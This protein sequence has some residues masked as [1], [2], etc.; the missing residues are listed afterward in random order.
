MFELIK[1]KIKRNRVL[2]FLACELVHCLKYIF[3]LLRILLYSPIVLFNNLLAN[4]VYLFKATYSTNSYYYINWKVVT[5]ID[6]YQFIDSPSPK[7]LILSG[8]KFLI[9]FNYELEQ[10]THTD[11]LFIKSMIRPDY[12]TFF[13]GVYQQCIGDKAITDIKLTDNKKLLYIKLIKLIVFLPLFFKVYEKGFKVSLFRYLKALTYLNVMKTFKNYQY[14][15]L[16]VF[17]DMQGVENLLVQYANKHNKRT[18]T[19]Q[20]GLYVDYSV[21]PNINIVNYESVVSQYFLAWGDETSQLI[22]KYHP[23]VKIV[24]CGKP[25][26]FTNKADPGD[27]FTIVFD[28]KL[29]YE[30]NKELLV[31]GKE[32][33]TVYGWRMNVRIHPW[34]KI[35]NYDFDN[36][37]TDFNKDLAHSQFVIGHTTSMIFECMR[38]GIPSFKYKTKYPSNKVNDSLTF[39]NAEQLISRIEGMNNYNFSEVGMYYLKYVGDESLEKYREF[40]STIKL[41]N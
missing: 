3:R 10:H 26:Y 7:R 40:F 35:E 27:Y 33:S 18:I 8:F 22:Q 5:K 41:H 20:H 4:I 37:L 39:A 25:V 24:V 30:Q 16:V 31:I 9:K 28:Q 36:E 15:T 1:D 29:F 23:D 14:S 21:F 6:Y 11:L 38:N 2:Y 32:I 12:N 19:L 13:E 34:D 17:A